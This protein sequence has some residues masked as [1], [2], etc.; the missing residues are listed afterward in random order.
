MDL[1]L[2][3]SVEC[4]IAEV[5]GHILDKNPAI[6]PYQSRGTAI[7]TGY[8]IPKDFDV[9]QSAPGSTQAK[10]FPTLHIFFLLF[11]YMQDAV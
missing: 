9:E 7:K 5:I 10:S 2:S 1:C 11:N 8:G 4:L 3:A 6:S